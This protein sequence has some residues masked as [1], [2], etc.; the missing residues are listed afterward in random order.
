MSPDKNEEQKY[1]IEIKYI[2]NDL[3]EDILQIYQKR[4]KIL[5]KSPSDRQ[6]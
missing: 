4:Q 5:Y 3:E 1:L 2:I 6:T